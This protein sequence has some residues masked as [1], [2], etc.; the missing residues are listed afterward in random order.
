MTQILLVHGMWR[1]PLCMYGMARRLGRHG[2][3]SVLFAYH[4]VVQTYEGIVSRLAAR[5]QR[6]ANEGPYAAVGY[7]LGG[8]LLRAAI[9][10]VVGRPPDHLVF[11]GTP[12]RPPRL[13]TQLGNFAPYKWFTGECGSRLASEEFY[14]R[15]P[16][17][18]IPYTIIA[19]SWGP[20]GRWSPFGNDINDGLVAVSETLVLDDDTPVVMPISHAMLPHSNAVQALVVEAIGGSST[21]QLPPLTRS[22]AG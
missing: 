3:A 4:P 10:Q 1:T 7:S 14:A 2:H 11:L 20:V 9:P 8:I 15:L 19:G 21:A 5:L 16:A 13:A 18:A 17:P 6:L 22:A 12:N